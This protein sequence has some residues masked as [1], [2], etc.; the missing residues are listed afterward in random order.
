MKPPIGLIIHVNTDLVEHYVCEDDG[1]CHRR[2]LAGNTVK[3]VNEFINFD[4]SD[5]VLDTEAPKLV[6]NVVPSVNPTPPSSPLVN[7][8]VREPV[9]ANL[10]VLSAVS[11]T[12]LSPP[13]TLSMQHSR[14][15]DRSHST[16]K[17]RKLLCS[18]GDASSSASHVVS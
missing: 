3:R 9:P 13:Y 1:K 6:S 15:R 14:S 11:S 7:M 2:W 17:R 12:I 16:L 8:E 4:I 10:S 5:V 18:P